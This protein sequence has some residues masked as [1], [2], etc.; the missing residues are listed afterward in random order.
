MNLDDL[1]SKYLDGELNEKED[2]VLREK[3]SGD[4]AAKKHFDEAVNI[5]MA[6]RDDADSI[7]PPKDFVRETEEKILMKIMSGQPVSRDKVYKMPARRTK[8]LAVAA[9][10]LFIFGFFRISD[11]LFRIDLKPLFADSIGDIEYKLKDQ[12]KEY[13]DINIYSGKAEQSKRPDLNNSML[14]RNDNIEHKKIRKE[15]DRNVRLAASEKKANP[16]QNPVSE[17]SIENIVNNEIAEDK[18]INSLASVEPDDSEMPDLNSYPNNEPVNNSGFETNITPD[19]TGNSDMSA[20]DAKI[21]TDNISIN[22]FQNTPGSLNIKNNGFQDNIYT[23]SLSGNQPYQL[24]NFY[25]NNTE[26][27]LS[28]FLGTDVFAGP[29]MDSVKSSLIAHFS[30]SLAYSIDDRSRIGVEV[31]YSEYTYSE[32]VG[33]NIPLSSVK[34][35]NKK[36]NGS[37]V[38]D[39]SSGSFN[40]GISGGDY[41]RR[42][43][44]YPVTKQLF[45]GSAFYEYS[46]F[47]K[48][49]F[50]VIGRLGAGA[51]SEGPLGYGKL[52]AKYEI[53]SGFALTLGG[54]GRFFVSSFSDR[55]NNEVMSTASLIYGFQFQF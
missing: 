20:A 7:E 38:E 17:E 3:L 24:I 53:L 46:I 30:Q 2:T 39:A 25:P 29:G 54:E 1:I 55:S 33:M 23:G 19:K 34:P 8:Y 42:P 41:I 35:G 47:Q 48:N 27:Q 50:S 5:H 28:S 16:E 51:T 22:S 18:T 10:A 32:N 6:F 21:S 43:F 37:Q 44:S 13:P 15:P 12:L 40:S 26:I 31:G 4:M 9:A 14:A 52:F 49:N 45:W 11:Q 36:G